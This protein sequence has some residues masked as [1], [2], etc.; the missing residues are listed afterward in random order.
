MVA[1]H[2]AEASSGDAYE[3]DSFSACQAPV[4]ASHSCCFVRG[5]AV[6]LYVLY[7]FS[8]RPGA[9]CHHGIRKASVSLDP[10]RR[11]GASGRHKQY[12]R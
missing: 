7:R 5:S 6:V 4:A 11:T 12:H 9:P 3:Y 1:L 10:G 8:P 2:P